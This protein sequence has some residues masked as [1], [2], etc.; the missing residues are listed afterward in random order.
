LITDWKRFWMAPSVLRRVLTAAG[1][2]VT[3]VTNVTDVGHL[4]SDADEG[5]DKVEAAA[6]Q[7]VG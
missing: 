5:E 7:E 1:Y 3:F 6:A 4:V 2:D